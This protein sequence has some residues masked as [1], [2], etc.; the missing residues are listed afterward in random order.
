[1]KN[2][3]KNLSKEELFNYFENIGEN[4]FRTNQLQNAIY[5]NRT[6]DF[7]S[8]SNFSANLKNKLEQDFNIVSLELIKTMLSSDGSTKFIFKTEDNNFIESVFLPN[9][10]NA[11]ASNRNTICVSTM[12]GCPVGCKFC[13]TGNF[14]YKRNLD[15]AEILDQILFIQQYFSDIKIKN[16]VFMGM[17]EPFLNYNN[18]ISAIRLILE[19]SL[20]N[21]KGITIST[22]GIPAAILDFANEGL[23]IKLALSLHSPFDN[24]RQKLIPIAKKYKIEEILK[25]LDFYYRSTHL[26]IT[27]EYILFKGLNDSNKDIKKLARIARRFPSVINLIPYNNIS[28]N[29]D[30]IPC[31][32]TEIKEFAKKLHNENIVVITRKSQGQDISAAC[33][34]LVCNENE[35]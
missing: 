16:A 9:N 19:F 23:K 29:L 2:N 33:G 3:I 6:S 8:I 7:Q 30:L 10:S 22:I 25:S 5:N 15:I 21:S 17:G 35:Y 18:L 31:N 1:M 34:M 4:K 32:E 28:K 20:L 26:P 12:A 24:N 27:L 13:A 14:G 11:D